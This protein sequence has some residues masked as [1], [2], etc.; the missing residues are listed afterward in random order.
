[1]LRTWEESDADWGLLHDEC[2]AIQFSQLARLIRQH[3]QANQKEKYVAQKIWP[4]VRLPKRFSIRDWGLLPCWRTKLDAS[5]PSFLRKILFSREFLG[6]HQYHVGTKSFRRPCSAGQ[7]VHLCL[8]G[9]VRFYCS[10]N[11]WKIRYNLWCL[12]YCLLYTSE[13]SCEDGSRIDRKR[14]DFNSR[15]N[16]HGFRS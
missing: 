8:W 10:V 14:C 3:W 5:D 7:L 4:L 15:R 1:M 9:Y 2:L 6:L 11:D 16:E 13:A 12:G